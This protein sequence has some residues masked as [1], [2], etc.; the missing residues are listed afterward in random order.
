MT[1]RCHQ[2]LHSPNPDIWKKG[3]LN[4]GWPCHGCMGYCEIQQDV[5]MP[6]PSFSLSGCSERDGGRSTMVSYLWPSS[7]ESLHPPDEQLRRAVQRK[8]WF[9]GCCSL[10]WLCFHDSKAPQTASCRG[11]DEAL[12]QRVN[13]G[14]TRRSGDIIIFIEPSIEPSPPCHCCLAGWTILLLTRRAHR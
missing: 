10:T 11:N 14:K 2:Q 4:H 3:P 8:V 9:G 5:L 12:P 6:A 1:D 13:C 7:M